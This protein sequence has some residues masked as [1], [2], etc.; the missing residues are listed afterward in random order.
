[1]G[2]DESAEASA[3]GGI[4]LKALSYDQL[5]QIKSSID[6]EINGLQG[7]HQQLAQSHKR[8]D[9]S[10]QALSTLASTPPQTRML[11][12]I[13]SNLYVPGETATIETVL[14]DVGTGY[15][16]EKSVPEAQAF[17]ERKSELLTQQQN[18]VRQTAAIKAQH[19]QQCV[20]AMSEKQAGR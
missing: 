17:L 20:S 7:A 14:V 11:V 3:S 16:I 5:V 2:D 15:Y 8:L 4:S 18:T 19:L 6:E 13:T 1:M 10:K 12:P 9:I